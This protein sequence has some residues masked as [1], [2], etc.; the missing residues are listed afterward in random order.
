MAEMKKRNKNESGTEADTTAWMVTFGDMLMLLLT[1]FVLLLSM[2][3]MDTKVLKS[4][5]RL[6]SGASGPL[7]FSH[8]QSVKSLPP[9][10]Q[11]GATGPLEFSDLRALELLK[12]RLNKIVTTQKGIQITS[13]EMLEEFFVTATGINHDKIAERLKSIMDISEDERGVIITFKASL[14]F[15][16]GEAEIKPS[17]LPILDLVARILRTVSNEVLIAGHT[18]NVPI[19][20]RRYNS[21][22]EL[23]LYRALNVHRYLVET[24]GLPPRRLSVGGY[25]D[26]RPRFPNTTEDGREKNRRVEI[27]LRVIKT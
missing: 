15:N 8:L 17:T 19:H 22:W 10:L 9:L 7:E 12:E 13:R 23:S 27:I 26:L 16:S 20:S 5:F 25:G 1:F 18:D 2:S 11:R 24:K 14:L 4:M 3:S 6:F 21:N